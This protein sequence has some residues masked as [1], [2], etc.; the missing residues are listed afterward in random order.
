MLSHILIFEDFITSLSN[1]IHATLRHI[2]YLS[3]SFGGG[4]FVQV[5][6]IKDVSQCYDIFGVHQVSV[7]CHN[8]A[9]PSS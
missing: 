1:D 8:R 6:L 9:Y 5:I 4:W 7:G 2:R 3:G